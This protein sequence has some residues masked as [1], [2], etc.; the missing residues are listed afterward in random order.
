MSP[1][2]RD[3]DGVRLIISPTTRWLENSQQKYKDYPL[4]YS[5]FKENGITVFIKTN[6]RF[7]YP[8]NNGEVLTL[9]VGRIAK[10]FKCVFKERIP[11]CIN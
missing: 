4:F 9:T 10:K 11:G 5:F 8:V 3:L 1:K 2:R 6:D 7:I